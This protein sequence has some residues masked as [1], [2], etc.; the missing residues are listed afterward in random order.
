[1]STLIHIGP[2]KT[3]STYIQKTLLNNKSILLENGF[4]YPDEHS[5]INIYGHHKVANRVGIFNT[6]TSL[7]NQL[8]SQIKNSNISLIISSECFDR[9][10]SKSVK[11]L[12]DNIYGEIKVIYFYRKS[13]EVFYS[14]WQENV[15]HGSAEC[16][17]SFILRHISK[18]SESLL[19]N[20]KIILNNWYQKNK[21]VNLSI[22]DYDYLLLNKKDIVN[23]FSKCFLNNIDLVKNNELVNKSLSIEKVELLRILNYF[24][25]RNNRSDFLK[26]RGAY[27][28]MIEYHPY[29]DLFFN[30]IKSMIC[31]LDISELYRVIEAIN[32]QFEYDYSDSF[33]TEIYNDSQDVKSLSLACSDWVF[34]NKAKLLSFYNDLVNSY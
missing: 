10:N 2:H 34:N 18:P 22:L 4:L 26:F 29:V 33:K 31:T 30:E 1:M 13:V 9:W 32:L 20:K 5:W 14:E 28:K 12:Y 17:K 24:H 16:F 27:L 15:K 6:D 25:I 21:N 19:I 8:N 23:E 11:N 7:Y 3:G